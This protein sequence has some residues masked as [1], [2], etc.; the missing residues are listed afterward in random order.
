VR[1]Y[2][3]DFAFYC[4]NN[5]P[6][7]SLFCLTKDHP[8]NFGERRAEFAGAFLTTFVSEGVFLSASIYLP[9]ESTQ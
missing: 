7:A 1:G 5:H 4:Q 9:F 2:L 3:E 8:Y 6:V